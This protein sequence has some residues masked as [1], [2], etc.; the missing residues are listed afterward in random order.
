MITLQRFTVKDAYRLDD[1]DPVMLRLND[2]ISQVINNFALYTDLRGVF[3]VDDNNRFSGV[4][5]RTDLLDWARVKFGVALLI[6]LFDTD[7]TIR[8]I[9]LIDTSKVCDILRQETNKVAVFANETLA[10]ALQMM[11]EADLIVLPVIDKSQHIIGSLT[12]SEILHLV[13]I[14]NQEHQ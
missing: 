12:L 9:T 10:H 5:T 7:K 3:V 4:I 14:K 2:E 13:L 11:I 8:L 6:P 1:E